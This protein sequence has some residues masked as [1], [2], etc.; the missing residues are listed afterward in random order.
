MASQKGICEDFRRGNIFLGVER[1]LSPLK[2][3]RT[4]FIFY[5][6]HEIKY[7]MGSSISRIASRA[8]PK[9]K[10]NFLYRQGGIR[11]VRQPQ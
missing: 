5:S 3:K 6:N 9:K 8:A 11:S 1:P 2:R 4:L 10:E 7:T